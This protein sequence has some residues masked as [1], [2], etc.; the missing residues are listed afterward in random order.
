[1]LAGLMPG[2]AGYSGHDSSLEVD[3]VAEDSM[4]IQR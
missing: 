2:A 3:A 1:M 4:G